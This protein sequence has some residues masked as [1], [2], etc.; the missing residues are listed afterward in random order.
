MK[1][2]KQLAIDS[3]KQPIK[4]SSCRM[5]EI[6]T[7]TIQFPAWKGKA[8]SENTK[9]TYSI[10]PLVEVSGEPLFGELAILRWLQKDDWNGVWVDSFHGKKL[11][12]DGLP[13]RTAPCKLPENPNTLYDKIAGI[14]GK[15][16][17]FFDVFA[18]RGG[19]FLFVEYKGKGDTL[20]PNQSS[21]ILS[22]LE[23]G[24]HEASLLLV[25]FDKSP[26]R[27]SA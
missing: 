22:A 3:F 7:L 20:K 17:G 8:L 18:W 9:K 6:L 2:L 23:A 12:W 10:K 1:H 5:V 16:G 13:D 21:W 19:E 4:V 15:A 24:I 11:F 26:G 25:E 27:S 14:N